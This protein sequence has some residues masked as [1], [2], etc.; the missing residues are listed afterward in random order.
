[1]T[2]SLLLPAKGDGAEGGALPASPVQSKAAG[3]ADGDFQK[4]MGEAQSGQTAPAA[5]KPSPENDE[6]KDAPSTIP[7][8]TSSQKPPPPSELSNFA[9]MDLLLVLLGQ[10]TRSD[11]VAEK[12][13][14]KGSSLLEPVTNS[15]EPGAKAEPPDTSKEVA[16]PGL[17]VA[18]AKQASLGGKLQLPGFTPV[19]PPAGHAASSKETA[20]TSAA[21]KAF[22]ADPAKTAAPETVPSIAAETSEA[23]GKNSLLAPYQDLL[24]SAAAGVSDGRNPALPVATGAGTT[25]ATNGQQVKSGANKNEIAGSAAQK[26]PAGLESAQDSTASAGLEVAPPAKDQP[27]FS[28]FKDTP[29]PWTFVDASAIGASAPTVTTN[30]ASASPLAN[31]R[32]DQVERLITREVVMVRQSGAEALAVSLK[33][34]AKTSLFLQLTNHDGQIEASVRCESGDAGALNSHWSQLQESLSHQNVQLLPLEGGSPSSNSTPDHSSGAA[35]NSPEKSKNEQPQSGPPAEKP[36]D[37]AMNAAVGVTKS[38]HNRPKSWHG[39]EKW[40]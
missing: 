19:A 34:D 28:S 15:T 22:Q 6:E 18:D 1:M 38:K 5:E 33:V 4:F 40:A 17:T 11:S 7:N 35:G 29:M 32:L 20:D 10:T 2:M 9:T 39:W 31:P 36:S 25:V 23:P 12:S 24:I 16:A 13:P 3:P 27:D 26:L 21:G 8:K 30:T 14:G 37:D